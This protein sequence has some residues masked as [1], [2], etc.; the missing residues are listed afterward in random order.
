MLTQVMTSTSAAP[1]MTREQHGPRGADHGAV[2]RHRAEH[3][4]VLDLRILRGDTAA[5]E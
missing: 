1:A 3:A 2:E 4:G 5:E